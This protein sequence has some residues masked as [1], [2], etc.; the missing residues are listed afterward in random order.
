LTQDALINGR[1]IICCKAV[2][3]LEI[4]SVQHMAQ[5]AQANAYLAAASPWMMYALKSFNLMMRCNMMRGWAKA[6]AVL[7]HSGINSVLQM[8]DQFDYVDQLSQKGINN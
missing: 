4:K 8:A 6:E 3:G 7:I 5:E 1:S 2:Q